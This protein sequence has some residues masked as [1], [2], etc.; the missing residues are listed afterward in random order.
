VA[1]L[2]K[3]SAQYERE[4]EVIMNSDPTYRLHEQAGTLAER[5]RRLTGQAIRLSVILLLSTAAFAQYGGG[6]GTVGTMG[7]PGA[8]GTAG[9]SSTP[10]YGHGKAIGIG[11]GA[12]VAGVGAVYLMTH[13][14][15]KVTGCV[16]TAD[17]GLH[18]T[19]DRSRRTLA[20]VPGAA[21]VK[22]GERLELKGKIRKS[23]AG[24]Q[25]FLVKTVA[26]DLGECHTQ[27]SAGAAG[28]FN[29]RGR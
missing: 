18:L 9:T 2:A 14:A 21:N 10:S 8:P 25:S 24:D 7:T 17:D 15:S 6:G 11:V 26:K 28:S 20:L 12:A 29:S 19:D 16:E 4:K 3:S 23:A 27:A 1:F 5:S 22:A 13:R